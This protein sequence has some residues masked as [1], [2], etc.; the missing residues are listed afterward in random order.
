[1]SSALDRLIADG[2]A[3]HLTPGTAEFETLVDVTARRPRGQHTA[4]DYRNPKQHAASFRTALNALGL[5]P[6]DRY[7]ALRFGGGQLVDLALR[8]AAA[9]AGIDHS[10]DMLALAREQ[11]VGA[12]VAGRLPLL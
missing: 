9:A 1:L 6:P 3:G 2:S 10:P 8:T 4:A 5:T 11:N 7:L 12:I